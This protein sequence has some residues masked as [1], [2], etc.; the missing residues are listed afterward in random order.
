MTETID[1][2]NIKYRGTVK[3]IKNAID[4]LERKTTLL[5]LYTQLR[6]YRVSPECTAKMNDAGGRL[7]TWLGFAKRNKSVDK[8]YV[9]T[10]YLLRIPHTP[11]DKRLASG[12][13]AA[14]YSDIDVVESAFEGAFKSDSPSPAVRRFLVDLLGLL[15]LV[16]NTKGGEAIPT[17]FLRKLVASCRQ[18]E[19]DAKCHKE[20]VCANEDERIEKWLAL[21]KECGLR[22]DPEIAEVVGAYCQALDPYGVYPE[23][24][25]KYQQVKREYFVRCP[26]STVWVW[27][28]DVPE[29]VRYSLY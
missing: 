20:E 16:K 28:D 7:M 13:P 9:A 2:E 29:P 21:R 4:M 18:Q 25:E 15:G 23:L 24:P 19:R 6:S 14:T 5:D 26:K 10:N 27:V 22:I 8:G 3:E 1:I 11:G 12:K 17:R